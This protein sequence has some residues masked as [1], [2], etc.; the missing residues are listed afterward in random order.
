MRWRVI[1]VGN[2]CAYVGDHSRGHA[3]LGVEH[4]GAGR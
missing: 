4:T 2:V 1:S 3:S